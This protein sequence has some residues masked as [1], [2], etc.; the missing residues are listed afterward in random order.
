[1]VKVISV[2]LPMAMAMTT[3][4]P[5]LMPMR[6]VMAMTNK[7]VTTAVAKQR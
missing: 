4:I 1:M 7:M 2:M 5:L 6:M 3:V